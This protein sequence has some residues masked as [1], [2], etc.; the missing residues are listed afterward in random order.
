M[1][2]KSAG[3]LQASW[4]QGTLQDRLVLGHALVIIQPTIC[5]RIDATHGTPRSSSL[6]FTSCSSN[7]SNMLPS[8]VRLLPRASEP[9][10][11]DIFTSS[12]GLIFTDDT[13]CQ[14][15]GLD[16]QV[17]YKSRKFAK[18]ITLTSAEPEGEIE[19]RKFAH[20]VWNAGILMGELVG[21]RPGRVE[22]DDMSLEDDRDWWLSETE[23]KA[24]DVAGETVLEL[25][26]GVGLGG[27]LSAL[28][29][30]SEVAITDYPAPTILEALKTNIAFNLPEKARRK[31]ILAGH[32]W[33]SLQDDFSRE[34]RGTYTRILAA[35]CLWMPHEHH[36]LARSM[37]HFLS[38]ADEA[39]VLVLAGFHTGRSN[40]A[41]FFEEVVPDEG[42]KVEE[43]WECD[44]DGKRRDW[45]PLREE[46]AGGER[47][48]WL[49]VARLRRRKN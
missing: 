24:W 40:L 16:A 49:V 14:H 8:L 3:V 23:Q 46:E 5:S 29:G 27:I 4:V 31:T 41:P 7:H 47:N 28:A 17:I 19:R 45:D 10:P 35:D 9:D 44:I 2:G 39:R 22:S 1:G 42:L 15:G 13:Q 33:G 6:S 36:N 18:D 11:E 38:P 48:K 37:L 20:Y 26:A 25:G 30:A 43:I 34:H 32:T 21:G 12:L